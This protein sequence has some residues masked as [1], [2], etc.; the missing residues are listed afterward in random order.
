[1]HKYVTKTIKN[2]K[3]AMITAAW[4]TKNFKTLFIYGFHLLII[5]SLNPMSVKVSTHKCTDSKIDDKEW[6]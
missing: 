3:Q 4:T 1:M 5:L 6:G 2:Q